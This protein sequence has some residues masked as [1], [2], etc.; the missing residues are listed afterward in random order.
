LPVALA[1]GE[2]IPAP[3]PLIVGKGLEHI[4]EALDLSKK[5]VSA[6]VVVT[7]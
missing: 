3:E 2:F 5:G 6:K 4:Q 7:L 1:Q